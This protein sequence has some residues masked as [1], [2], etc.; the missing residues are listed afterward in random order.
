M[1]AMVTVMLEELFE[2]VKSFSFFLFFFLNNFLDFEE[3]VVMIYLSLTSLAETKLGAGRT[4]IPYTYN[5][6]DKTAF[7][8]NSLMN[9]AFLFSFFGLLIK[10]L[11]FQAG[12]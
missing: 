1:M 12:D 7:A 6:Q 8:L 10:D 2:T 4:F 9:Q 11:F 5:R 3:I